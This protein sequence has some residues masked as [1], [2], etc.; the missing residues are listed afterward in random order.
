MFADTSGVS[1]ANQARPRNSMEKP[2]E[3][4]VLGCKSCVPGQQHYCRFCKVAGVDHLSWRCPNKNSGISRVVE[5]KKAGG[6][7]KAAIAQARGF[8]TNPSSPRLVKGKRAAEGGDVI[9]LSSNEPLPSKKK[10]KLAKPKHEKPVI[11]ADPAPIKKHANVQRAAESKTMIPVTNHAKTI[12]KTEVDVQQLAARIPVPAPVRPFSET[13][14]TNQQ[15]VDDPF[16]A[17]LPPLPQDDRRQAADQVKY[18]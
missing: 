6:K 11:K 13:A 10:Q 16:F 9:D 2:G 7:L 15:M 12:L 3:C 1:P 18:Q 8:Q 4:G 17:T 14:G 5:A